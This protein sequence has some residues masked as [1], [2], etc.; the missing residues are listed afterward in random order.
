MTFQLNSTMRETHTYVYIYI[1]PLGLS[2]LYFLVSKMIFQSNGMP[3]IS[4]MGFKFHRH[5]LNNNDDGQ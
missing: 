1:S 3:C 4:H 2:G 5:E